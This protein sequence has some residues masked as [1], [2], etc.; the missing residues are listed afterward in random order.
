MHGHN[1]ISSFFKSRSETEGPEK[2]RSETEGPE[3]LTSSLNTI[4]SFDIKFGSGVLS[5]VFGNYYFQ[6]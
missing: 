2:L 4:T 3:K 6:M 1:R 5:K